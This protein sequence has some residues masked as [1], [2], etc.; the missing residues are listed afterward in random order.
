M[1]TSY[2]KF[3]GMTLTSAILMYGVMYLNTYEIGH[4]YF[5]ETRL[6][7]TIMSTSVMAVVM[8]LF[9]LNMLSNKK[10]YDYSRCKHYYLYNV[11]YTNEK[12]NDYR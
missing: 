5:S 11:I 1:K 3:L 2:L 7:M 8:L 6:Y 10:K 9:M 4:I 12:S